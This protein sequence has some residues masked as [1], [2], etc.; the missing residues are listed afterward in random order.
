MAVRLGAR[1]NMC[2]FTLHEHIHTFRHTYYVGDV[3]STRGLVTVYD[4]VKRKKSEEC[5]KERKNRERGGKG[6]DKKIIKPER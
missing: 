2:H 4:K 1:G 6:L 3:F 5:E